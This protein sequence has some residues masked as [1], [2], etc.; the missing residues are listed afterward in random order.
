MN[1]FPENPDPAAEDEA[2]LW[3]ARLEGS[4]LN[5]SDRAALEAWLDAGPGRRE[6]LSGYV[7]FSTELEQL[8]PE[9]AGSGRVEMPE[10]AQAP[11][12][13]WL[14]PW[15]L[16]GILAAAALVV[17]VAWLREPAGRPETIATSAAQRRSF[18][19]ADGTRVELNANTSLLIENGRAERR[20]RLADGEA[21]FVVSKDKSRPFIVETPAG[22]VRVTGTI[23]NVRTQAA[24][25]LVV[26]VVEGSVQVRPGDPRGLPASGPVVLGAGD[27]LLAGEGAVSVR[28]LSPN[29]LDDALAWRQG[30]IVFDGV[31]L[32]EALARAAQYHG[33]KITVSPGAAVLP[34]GGRI[35]LDNLDGFFAAIETALPEVRV[36]RDAA[37]GARVSLRAER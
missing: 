13:R 9:L 22:S 18:T 24:S 37:G 11:R 33:R 32:A 10:R 21:Y 25:E 2:A 3:A 19:L 16:T 15:A 4:A 1:R 36:T 35:R 29:A 23:F 31:P 6:L 20:V 17:A 27:R 34:L 26:T 7:E 14:S 8:V 28:A 5:A 12:G 30:Q